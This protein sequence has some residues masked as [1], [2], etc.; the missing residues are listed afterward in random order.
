LY[1][2][3]SYRLAS[4]YYS[5]R[6]YES[7][8][9]TIDDYLE[10]FSRHQRIDEVRVLKG[11]ILMGQGELDDAIVSF[12][13]VT[14]ESSYLFLYGLFQT[15][16]I[17]R[18]QENYPAMVSH[19]K[20]FLD[21][22]ESP[23]IRVSEALYWLGWAYQQLNRADLA[24]PIFEEDLHRYGD[25]LAATETQ[26][27]LQALERIK[28]RQAVEQIGQ[29]SSLINSRDFKS[30][31]TT[32]IRR[33]EK[34]KMLTYLSRLVLYYHNR[35]REEGAG[36]YTILSL[37]E[38][39]SME[40]LDPEAL[41]KVGLALLN[42]EDSRSSPYFSHL[43]DSFP[44]SIAR[45]MGYLGLARIADENGDFHSSKTWPNS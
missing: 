36:S 19:F 26:S 42:K 45:A 29:E 28:K 31:L 32:E 30:W 25:D 9:T 20:E 11:D 35:Y 34:N 41:G 1:P 38:G 7:D 27:I 24:Y 3:I 39:V 6:N 15:G 5:S 13:Q 37:A 33:A 4:A 8:L 44:R 2:E 22:Q 43:V 21:D 16:K 40:M 17:L 18:A 14:Q 23:K 12:D 10:R